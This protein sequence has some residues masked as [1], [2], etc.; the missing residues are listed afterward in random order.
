MKKFIFIFLL[1]ISISSFASG[2]LFQVT[3]D[4][5]GS[6]DTPTGDTDVDSGL[7]LTSEWNIPFDLG[8]FDLGIGTEYQLDRDIDTG[9]EIRYWNTYLVFSKDMIN[10][11]FNKLTPVFKIG[12]GNPTLSGLPGI[13][14]DSGIFYSIGLKYSI[15]TLA[16]AEISYSVNNNEFTG[17]S[18]DVDYTRINFTWGTRFD[19]M[20]EY[21]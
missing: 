21:Y 17:T 10:N 19:Y 3:M 7:S 5:S 1:I 15:S 4:V 9:G 14:L 6:L 11:S 13:S 2:S 18:T 12:R 8:G 20:K 16:H